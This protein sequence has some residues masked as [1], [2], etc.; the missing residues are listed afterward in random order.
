VHFFGN[1]VL[2][3]LY[4]FKS[5]G[6]METFLDSLTKSTV[7]ACLHA[8]EILLLVSGLVLLIGI[9]G[10][11]RKGEKWKKYLPAFQV[12]VLA[13][14][15]VELF[16]DAG[17]F[18]FS[19]SLQRLEGADIQALDKKARS[20]NDKAAEALGMSI[21]AE[22]RS[23]KADGTSKGALAKSARAETSSL[24]ALDLA[25]GARQEADSFEK[26][27]VSAKKQATEAEAHLT[28]ALQR[29]AAAES[30]AK[31]AQQDEAPRRLSEQQKLELVRLLS[32]APT[33]TVGFEMPRSPSGESADFL[34]DLMDVFV[35][36]KL[37]PPGSNSR[38]LGR[39]LGSTD[40]SGVVVGVMSVAEHPPA[41]DV[42]ISTLRNWGFRAS[43]EVAPRVAKSATEM[44][45]LV[46]GKQ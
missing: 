46:G 23:E 2:D 20:A 41:A 43:G 27:I 6:D 3:V 25:K 15:G 32:A 34:N 29:A 36:M 8:S 38:A 31:K 5:R 24:S 42:L 28:E 44:R 10:E 11:Y 4:D 37:I 19:E 33:F 14:I 9:W 12:M 1:N 7:G 26:D 13:G 30:A 22:D 39:D 17:V 16:A 40:A 18:L 45:I 35:R 21:T